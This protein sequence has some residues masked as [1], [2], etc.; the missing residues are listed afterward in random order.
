M[1]QVLPIL[2]AIL[3]VSAMYVQAALSAA[4][5]IKDVYVDAS[6]GNDANPGTLEKPFRSIQRAA[7]AMSS[8]D[9]CYIRAGTYRETVKPKADGLTFRSF[10]NEHALITGLDVVTGWS[11][12]QGNIV[13]AAFTRQTTANFKATQV[14]VNGNRMHW[15]RYP[16]E[17]GNMLN[18]ADMAGVT[19]DLVEINGKKT[20]RVTVEGLP[21]GPRDHWKGAYFMG[22][23]KDKNWWSAN[24]GHVTASER[25]TLTCGNISMNWSGNYNNYFTGDG[26]GYIIGHLNA[27]DAEK[28]WHWQNNTLYLYPPSGTDISGALVEARSRVFGFDLTGRTGVTLQGLHFKAAGLTMENAVNCTVDKC[29]FRY[30]SS[31]TAYFT[32]P[33][34]DY[35]NGDGGVFVSGKNNTIRN[36][37]IGR[38][39]GHGVSL[40]GSHQTLENCIVEQCNWMGERMSPVWAPGDD[41]IIRR[42]TMRF[43]AREGIELGNA[44]WIN[45]YAKRALIQHNHVHDAGYLCPDGGLFY[46]NHQRGSN[47]LANTEISYNVW[48]DYRKKHGAAAHGGIYTDNN[49][50]GYTIHHNVIWNVPRGFSSNGGDLHDVYIYH[51]TLINVGRPTSWPKLDAYKNIVVRNN[52]SDGAGFQ[53]TTVDHNREKAPLS[54][55][56]DA[57]RHNYRLKPSSLSIDK[58]VALPGINDGAINAPDLGAYEYGGK[59]WTAGADIQGLGFPDE[60]EW[61]SMPMRVSG[62]STPPPHAGAQEPPLKVLFD[63]DG[64]PNGDIDDAFALI[65]LLNSP[66]IDVRGVTTRQKESDRVANY[67][68][69]IID[70]MGRRGDIPVYA[71]ATRPLR[72][73]S[74]MTDASR[75][76]VQSIR[77]ANG[78]RNLVVVGS[79]T[80]VARAVLEEPDLARNRLEAIYLMGYK[81]DTLTS[82]FNVNGDL[83]AADILLK[84]GIPLRVLPVEI[85][86]KS[87]LT[88]QEYDTI[89]ASDAP[90]VVHIKQN[91]INWVHGIRERS[92]KRWGN[93]YLDYLPRPYDSLTAMT[94]TNPE[95]FQWKRGTIEMID[96]KPGAGHRKGNTQ[97]SESANGLHEIVVGVDREKAM[98]LHHKRLLA[99]P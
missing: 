52:I 88:Q 61:D 42:N 55:F 31:F 56:V 99:W 57:G 28:E 41:N 91:M 73:A 80:N 35:K 65:Y 95:L 53:G 83:D 24:K 63:T 22:L 75:F 5:S 36:C 8:G 16:N 50:S 7:D 97:F 71:G 69:E 20:G 13:K 39:W 46:V 25:N 94:I 62:G 19:V 32:N 70:V 79:F 12:H 45:K 59:D 17:D 77:D 10:E 3:C 38:T 21:E 72:D 92:V 27:L 87:Q 11:A 64:M 84:S 47:P 60:P 48:H 86:I 66:D 43:S 74:G 15:A 68:R 26:W 49:S 37:Y 44:G 33:W 29:T 23:A 76:I 30:A 89:L 81:F 96:L 67:M 40:W 93:Q 54:D 58:G 6:N 85:G 2:I 90:Q 34:G 9:T 14:F 78:P 51:N 18:T 82:P 98:A 4:D 1:K